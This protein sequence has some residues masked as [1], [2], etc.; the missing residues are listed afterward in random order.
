MLRIFQFL[1][2][3]TFAKNG[4]Q[5][6]HNSSTDQIEFDDVP[7]G[8]STPIK[9]IFPE[10]SYHTPMNQKHIYR[11]REIHQTVLF[12]MPEDHKNDLKLKV[13]QKEDFVE[14]I[15]PPSGSSQ[16]DL[17][18]ITKMKPKECLFNSPIK[19]LKSR[20]FLS[21]DKNLLCEWKSQLRRVNDSG[22]KKEQISD[23][24]AINLKKSLQFDDCDVHSGHKK[25]LKR[26]HN[27]DISTKKSSPICLNDTECLSNVFKRMF[28]NDR[29]DSNYSREV[30]RRKLNDSNDLSMDDDHF[31]AT[32]KEKNTNSLPLSV[33][34]QVNY[35]FVRP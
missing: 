34:R 2:N 28:L 12:A 25:I 1:K 14:I 16:S 31:E 19:T 33:F 23:N 15:V 24:S 22:K 26:R 13:S 4:N 18:K 17:Y 8:S 35:T 27:S 7:Q 30:K 10:A 11:G 21:T 32:A 20:G 5:S 3:F 29:H 9:A 6:T